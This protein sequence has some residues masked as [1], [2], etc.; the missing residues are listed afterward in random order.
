MTSSEG[1][2]PR[3]VGEHVGSNPKPKGCLE[4]LYP[5]C[6]GTSIPTLDV[7]PAVT[8]TH[9]LPTSHRPLTTMQMALS[10]QGWTL[11]ILR[12]PMCRSEKRNSTPLSSS[13]PT[14]IQ[15]RAR[16]HYGELGR[17]TEAPASP[18]PHEDTLGRRHLHPRIEVA[19]SLADSILNGC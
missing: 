3:G 11:P 6:P 8:H 10:K 14:Q 7:Y 15:S 19:Q 4:I 17:P 5:R 18:S 12:T 2:P 16:R 9:V 13:Q 1:S